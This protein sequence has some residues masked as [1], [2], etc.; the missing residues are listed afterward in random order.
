MVPQVLDL[1]Y[2]N[3]TDDSLPGNFWLM[4][5]LRA[6]Y[7]SDNELERIP[8]DVRGLTNLVILALRDNELMEL[9]AEIGELG[10]LREL[11]LQGNRLTVLPPQLGQ[12]DLLSSRS[13]LKLDNNP[14]VPPI[15]NQLVLGVAHVVEYIRTDTYRYMHGRHIQANVP[16]PERSERAARRQGGGTL[17]RNN[18]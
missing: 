4:S 2:N 3:L 18:N 10:N 11:H 6:L 16:P 15:E 1:S 9:P 8:P 17:P 13:V 12:L 7:L 5:S 14:W